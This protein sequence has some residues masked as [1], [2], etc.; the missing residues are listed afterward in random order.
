[1]TQTINTPALNGFVRFIAS[2]LVSNWRNVCESDNSSPSLTLAGTAFKSISLVFYSRYLRFARCGRGKAL[3]LPHCSSS[4][5]TKPRINHKMRLGVDSFGLRR[6]GK[7]LGLPFD[8]GLPL[9]ARAGSLRSPAARAH[10]FMLLY[11]SN[12]I[13]LSELKY[14]P[15]QKFFQ[16][17][18]VF[19][20]CAGDIL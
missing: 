17:Y 12:L 15:L 18:A 8:G 10:C 13:D 20:S 3:L 4:S 9:V 19:R 5:L 7:P 14:P 2:Q 6:L 1:M 16:E 11:I